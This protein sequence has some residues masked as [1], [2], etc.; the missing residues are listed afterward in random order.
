MLDATP[1][2]PS[3]ESKERSGKATVCYGH[4][5]CGHQ[6]RCFWVVFVAVVGAVGLLATQVLSTVIVFEKL[7]LGPESEMKV[8]IKV[9]LFAMS[10]F[11]VEK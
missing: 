8:S 10:S 7:Q 1:Q 6:K 3:L 11:E 9:C 2:A 5:T 4:Q